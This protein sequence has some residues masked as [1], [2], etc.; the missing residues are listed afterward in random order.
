MVNRAPSAMSTLVFN[1]EVSNH[2]SI[3]REQ[4]KEVN[5]QQKDIYNRI[6]SV[7]E[8][9]EFVVSVA[10]KFPQFPIIANQRCG[11]WYVDP[12][13]SP[14]CSVYFK[15]TDGHD[16]QWQFSVRRSNLHLV[17]LIIDR[18]G[19]LIV[20]STRRG[21]RFPDA[22]S[23]TVPAWCA[24]LNT[25]RLRLMK[26][27]PI[28]ETD[29]EF[30]S[31]ELSIR[32][33]TPSDA[34][35]ASEHDQMCQRIEDWA[36]ELLSSSFDFRRSIAQL[37]RPLRPVWCCP[38]SICTMTDFNS[39]EDVLPSYY[40]V[41]CVSASKIVTDTS[42]TYRPAGYT[43]VQG[44]G[45][46]HES[47]SGGLTPTTFWKHSTK[48]LSAS[49]HDIPNLLREI[50][51]EQELQKQT[52]TASQQRFNIQETGLNISLAD[53][54]T[55]LGS[56]TSLGNLLT[57][58]VSTSTD[59][60]HIVKQG[61]DGKEVFQIEGDQSVLKNFSKTL[62]HIS[63]KCVQALRDRGKLCVIAGGCHKAQSQ[64]LVVAI[65]L[66][67]LVETFD[68]ARQLR[69]QSVPRI[70]KSLIRSRL[71]WMIEASDGSLNPS[72]SVLKRV[73]NFLIPPP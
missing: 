60:I 66:C 72:R 8:D 50:F 65:A 55:T 29:R 45:D 67:V 28:A 44:A 54:M 41:V 14:D 42:T 35:R 69:T 40:P 13:N 64:E 15:S 7:A 24:V 17:N 38:T 31:D 3:F 53:G 23:K 6:H 22:L 51:A 19:V 5:K 62:S 37:K 32:L 71:Q 2:H 25:V 33:S 63:P 57:V 26:Q 36:K 48:I 58:L 59:Q 56:Q 61:D 52:S 4:E 11:A 21:K 9:C 30:W 73:N 16:G 20:D 27:Y 43:Y 39:N 18:K 49:R 10:K 47:W 68:D 34:V 1:A 12:A 46:D 70:D